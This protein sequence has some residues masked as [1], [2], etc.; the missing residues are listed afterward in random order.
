[1]GCKAVILAAG[2]GSRLSPLTAAFPKELLPLGG[3]PAI[4]HVVYEIAQAG[5]TDV[6]IVL[7]QGKES[8]KRYFTEPCAP[9]GDSALELTDRRDRLI[10]QMNIVY[11]YQRE[12]NGTGGAVL[13][14]KEFAA[15]DHLLV[16]YPDDVLLLDVPHTRAP[17]RNASKE[18][19]AALSAGHSVIATELV[20]GSEAKQYGVVYPQS[21]KGQKSF[22][23]VRRIVEKPSDYIGFTAH[24][25]I[26]RMLL[27]PECVSEIER[28]PLSDSEGVIP[29]LNEMARLGK[30]LALQMVGRMDVGSHEGYRQSVELLAKG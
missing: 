15:G 14:A 9:K 30:L 5:I 29:A 8:V 28:H 16:A 7:S 22:F 21:E 17:A 1:M 2:M 13:L 6:M 20:S 3:L 11:A 25:L 23:S 10:S 27:S 26:G 24:V 12:R 18:M 4:H 19:M